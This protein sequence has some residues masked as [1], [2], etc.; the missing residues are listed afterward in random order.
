MKRLPLGRKRGATAKGPHGMPPGDRPAKGT[1]LSAVEIHD[2]ILAPA[3]EELERPASAL[4]WSALSSGLVIGFSFLA[5]A[6]M[7]TLVPERLGDAAAAVVYPLGFILVIMARSALFTENTIVPIMPL[8]N[9]RTRQ[10]LRKVLRLWS[11]LL[12]GNLVGALAFAWALARTPM[13]A[14]ELQEPLR[15]MAE[16]ATRGGFWLVG[17]QAIFAGWLMALLTWVLASTSATGAQIALIWLA[18]API[19]AFH[20]RHSIAGSVEALYLVVS[21]AVTPAHAVLEFIVPAV[22]G[23]AIGGVLLVALVNYAQVAR[24]R[25]PQEG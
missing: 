1:R 11:I 21:R 10:T 15:W 23:N 4:L 9:R 14:P 16:S 22:L 19:A 18:T 25:P 5:G 8:L 12:A 20:F 13:V 17:Y 3:E 24:E 6:Y 2:N 7:Q